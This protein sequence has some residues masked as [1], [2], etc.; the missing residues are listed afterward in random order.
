MKYLER[1]II[2]LLY[3]VAIGS[4]LACIAGCASLKAVG[5]HATQAGV[6]GAA[7]LGAGLL[8]LPLFG[9]LAV[10]GV[11]GALGCLF[12]TPTAVA[13][14]APGFPWTLLVLVA[15]GVLVLRSWAHWSAILRPMLE[16]AKAAARGLLGGKNPTDAP[17]VG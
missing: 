7:G 13:A 2:G 1:F 3:G 5:D 15:L 11:F 17:P 16:T 12:A 6:G 8:G 9:A 10:A 4:L 14:A